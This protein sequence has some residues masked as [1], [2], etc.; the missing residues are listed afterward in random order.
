MNRGGAQR[1]LV[2]LANRL[3]SDQYDITVQSIFD[4]GDLKNDLVPTI[5][6]KTIVSCKNKRLFTLMAWA[7]RRIL[8]LKLVANHF[9]DSDYDLEIAYLE[10][11]STRLIANHTKCS[12][13]K[14][15]WVHA[16]MMILFTVQG[17][18][19]T[20]E[21]HR[22]VYEQFDRIVCV[23]EGCREGFLQRFGYPADNVEVL[24]NLVNCDRIVQKAAEAIEYESRPGLNIVMVGNCRKEKAYDRMLSVCKRL[25]DEGY[26]FNV[27]I[28]GS[29]SEY[30]KLNN[31]CRQMGMDDRIRMPGAVSN[32]YPYMKRADMLVCSSVHEAFS[33]AVIEACLLSLP[34]LTTN[35]SGMK[36]ILE[37]GKYG[38]I[39]DNSEEGLCEGLR[40]VL[41]N[42]EILEHYREIL[43]QRSEFFAVSRRIDETTNLF[44]RVMDET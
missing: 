28:L 34:T 42:P 6:Y 27:T 29:G 41:D 19:R 38:M 39:V 1:V 12:G 14:I 30:M 3:P 44:N 13:K 8:P 4:Q 26:S 43:P 25:F 35:C 40:K 15:A 10:G 11:E 16:D 2:D 31:S 17:L 33:T 32:P 36:E 20:L 22:R 9:L 21:D 7:V 5:R 24:Y 18:Y 37:D 23:S